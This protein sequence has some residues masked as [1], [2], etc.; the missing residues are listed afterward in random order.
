MFTFI[1]R[2]LLTAVK[3]EDH[4]GTSCQVTGVDYR[5]LANCI[6][7]IPGVV[8][9]QK[10]SHL[11]SGLGVYTEFVLRGHMFQIEADPW[12]G[13]LWI[14][15]KDDTRHPDELLNILEHVKKSFVTV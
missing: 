10:P 3:V 12:D 15:P 2:L 8:F 11:W 7:Q 9:P 5:P 4:G 6:A 13:S 14:A 1:K